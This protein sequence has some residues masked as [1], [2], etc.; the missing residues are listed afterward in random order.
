MIQDTPY[1][2]QFSNSNLDFPTNFQS[3]ETKI[4]KVGYGVGF[5]L[6]GKGSCSGLKI[7]QATPLFRFKCSPSEGAA[8]P[9]FIKIEQK[10]KKLVH[11]YG[12]ALG[13][14]VIRVVGVI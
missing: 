13:G 2:K 12:L 10:F 6:G 4:A 3:N 9:C 1:A 5:W 7:S 11:F 8:L 14:G